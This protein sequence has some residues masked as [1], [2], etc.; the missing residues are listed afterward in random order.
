MS[1][2]FGI[3]PIQHTFLAASYHQVSSGN[4]DGSGRVQVIVILIQLKVVGGRKPVQQMHVRI[5]LDKALAELGSAVPTTISGDQVDVAL[6]IH[7][8]RLTRL[9]D[10]C[11]RSARRSIEDGN[12]LQRRFV[13]AEQESVIGVLV[14]M[15]SVAYQDIA[16]GKNKGRALVLRQWV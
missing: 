10:A 5:E 13:V 8:R 1:K 6:V 2:V 3:D 16:P 4:Q 14:T 15:R 12:L 11:F 7:G 9:P